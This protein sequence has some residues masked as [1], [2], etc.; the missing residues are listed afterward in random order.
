MASE[1]RLIF[2][3]DSL[4]GKLE[5]KRRAPIVASDDPYIRNSTIRIF[6]TATD[7]G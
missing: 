7:Q 1:S 3:G 2:R 4:Q 6:H 5:L